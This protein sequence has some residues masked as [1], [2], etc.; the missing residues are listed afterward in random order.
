MSQMGSGFK[1]DFEQCL[2]NRNKLQPN[3]W[4]EKKIIDCLNFCSV[5]NF[6]IVDWCR[7]VE[8][9]MWLIY[10]TGGMALQALKHNNAQ[11]GA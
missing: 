2:E 10:K 1:L 4:L 7:F 8:E 11:V 6:C 5:H 3:V 9:E